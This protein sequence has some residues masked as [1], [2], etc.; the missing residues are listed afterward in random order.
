MLMLDVTLYVESLA[1]CL[2]YSRCSMRFLPPFPV[3]KEKIQV[4]AIMVFPLLWEAAGP[5]GGGSKEALTPDN[6][7]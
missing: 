7:V 5:T 6:T 1:Q 4:V 2:S 3:L